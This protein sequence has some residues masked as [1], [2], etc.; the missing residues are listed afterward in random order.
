VELEL[1]DAHIHL[2]KDIGKERQALPLPGRRDRDRWGNAESITRY[3]DWEGVSYAV[4]LNLFPTPV[5]RR[6]LRAKLHPG[7][8]TSERAAAEAAI[9][10]DLAN[11]LRRHNE[12]LCSFSRQQPRVLAGIGIQK[13]LSPD[14]MVEEVELRVAQGARAVKLIPGWYREFPHDRAYWPMYDRCQELGIPIVADTGTLGLGRHG[15]YPGEVNTI[16][17]GEPFGFEEVLKSFPRLTVVMAHFG[18]AYW[19]QRLELAQRYPKLVFDISGGFDAPGLKVRDGH[20]ALHEDDAVRV[21]RRIGIERFMFG[22]D[23]PHVMVQPYVEQVLRL[24]LRQDELAMLLAANA[25]RIYA[26]PD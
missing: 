20:R 26:I 18:S 3:L 1:I 11:R 15:A 8:T 23:G 7:L 10:V 14:E 2:H 16:C 5:I 22:S 25:R 13:L 21:M 9:E 4:S 12:W 6:A 17:Y 24:G 19:D